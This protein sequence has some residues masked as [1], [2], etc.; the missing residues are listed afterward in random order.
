[1]KKILSFALSA[2]MAVN[3]SAFSAFNA[4][5]NTMKTADTIV[6]NQVYNTSICD[7]VD[8]TL[9][10]WVKFDCTATCYY[11]FVCTSQTQPDG[12]IYVTVYDA[13]QNIIN[14][15]SNGISATAFSTVSYLY[16]GQSY[17]FCVETDGAL[18]TL[19]AVLN[20]HNHSYLNMQQV[21]AVGDDTPEIRQDGFT[22][23]VCEGC[24][25]YYDSA[26]YFYPSEV[27]LSQE[28][29][30]YD[31]SEKYPD[32]T[33]YDRAGA[34]ISPSEYSVS[35]EDNVLPGKAFVTVTFNSQIY[36]GELTKS[37][38]VI[39]KKQT[40]T[41]LKSKKSKSITV[42]W[43]KD[44]TASGYEL[45]YSTSPKFYKSKT[46]TV[47]VAKIGAVSKTVSNLKSK[48]KYYV[49]VRSYKTVNSVKYYG[50]WS[51]KQY[52]KTMK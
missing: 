44:N 48:K 29:F 34:I 40:L 32:V 11:D 22:R 52:V 49:R 51:E 46:V 41:Y 9:S 17:Y 24:G 7:T 25:A 37:F 38:T 2:V 36:D 8:T 3:V 35:Y 14:F 45:Q 13:A 19:D 20:I 33:V 4:Y 5:A 16:A 23:F 27:V 26:T 1:M 43:S 10:S 47:N 21:K 31:G 12:A 42:K 18:C 39:P 15:S 50:A 30:T 6:L 28:K